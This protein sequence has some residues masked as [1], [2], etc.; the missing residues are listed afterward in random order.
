MF[1]LTEQL[2][3]HIVDTKLSFIVPYPQTNAVLCG[4]PQSN[5]EQ[6]LILQRMHAQYMAELMNA[7]AHQQ[8]VPSVS[9][10]NGITTA[11]PR[12]FYD[13]STHTYDLVQSDDVEMKSV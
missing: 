7:N 12:I 2:S 5:L 10:N 13:A 6:Q 3:R 11:Q 4:Y 9:N 1:I 8:P